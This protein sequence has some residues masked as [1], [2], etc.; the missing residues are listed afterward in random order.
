MAVTLSA[1]AKNAAVNAVTALI[2]T[3]GAGKLQIGTGTPSSFGSVL[4]SLALS[5]TAFGAASGGTATA[6]AITSDTDTAAGTATAFRI[7]DG[8]LATVLSGTVGTSGADIIFNSTS[9][10]L[11]G[12][13]SV[14]SLTLTAS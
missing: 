5:G 14:S 11:H 3:G 6:N 2:N 4:A 9:F 10:T 12:T 7:I 13:C 1:A 8:A